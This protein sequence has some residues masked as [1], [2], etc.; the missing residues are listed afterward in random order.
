[1][2][3]ANLIVT[4][5]VVGLVVTAAILAWNVKST[6]ILRDPSLKNNVNTISTSAQSKVTVVPDKVEVYFRITT[7]GA[8]AIDAQEKN[9]EASNSVMSAL[10]AKGVKESE[11]EST[12]YSI[13]K[14]YNYNQRTGSQESNGYAVFHVVKV[15]TTD[16][17]NV[18][19][20]A[21]TGVSAG[22]NGIDNILFTL[23]DEKEKQ[24]RKEALS[25][26][27]VLAKEKA[28]A[29]ASGL[30][31]SLG[32]LES[33][34]ESGFSFTPYNARSYGVTTTA[35]EDFSAP[36]QI[37][38]ENLIVTASVSVSYEIRTLALSY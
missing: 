3:K 35:L 28:E 15:S 5:L 12:Q 23:S 27:A 34:S 4:I 8:N 1:M 38:P 33:V 32:S 29:L 18:G 31:V 17:D 36:T 9:K 37:S 24:V 21:D 14:K 2:E 6:T 7:D 26:A 16:L 30:G 19:A 25:K 13:N 22:A 11:L 20:L 10:K